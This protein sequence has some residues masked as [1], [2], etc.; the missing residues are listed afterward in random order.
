MGNPILASRFSRPIGIICRIGAGLGG[1]YLPNYS[2][3]ARCIVNTLES[4]II[5]KFHDSRLLNGMTDFKNKKGLVNIALVVCRLSK[6]S[7]SSWPIDI[8][9]RI[10]AEEACILDKF[11][12]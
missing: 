1:K 8:A 12:D 6:D 5:S 7:R 11:E 4:R 2:F 3:I 10:R 9:R